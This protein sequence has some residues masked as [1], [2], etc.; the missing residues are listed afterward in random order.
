MFSGTCYR[1]LSMDLHDAAWNLAFS[2]DNKDYITNTEVEKA[3]S[4]F[5]HVNNNYCS[6]S[7]NISDAEKFGLEKISNGSSRGYTIISANITGLD[8]NKLVDKYIDNDGFRL[9][10]YTIKCLQEENE[11]LAP[12]TSNY[13]IELIYDLQD[14]KK[15]VGN[16]QIEVSKIKNLLE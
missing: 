8:L 1:A 6:W 15:Y 13:K 16:Y 9:S 10:G 4:E 12:M 14:R 3:L 2:L 7:K 11:I 5:I